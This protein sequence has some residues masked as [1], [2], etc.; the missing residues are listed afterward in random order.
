VRRALPLLLPLLL[1]VACHRGEAPPPPRAAVP[2]ERERM[3]SEQ[4]E[5]RGVRDERVLAAMRAVPREEFVPARLRPHAHEDRPLPIEEGQTISQPYIVAFMTEA[6]APEAADRV[7][8]IGTGSGYQAAV[9]AQLVAGVWS[10][11]LEPR[12]AESARARLERLA[13]R[14]VHLRQ[15]DGYLGWPEQAP[16]DAIVVTCGAEHVPAP[17]VEQ[18]KPGGRLVIPVGPLDDQWLR[19]VEKRADGTTTSRDAFPVRFV[20]LR[21]AAPAGDR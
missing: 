10:I 18:L 17:L 7:L 6:I 13:V 19:I 16:F 2:G 20:P 15:G 9:L 4:I 11:E 14:N 3:V 5:A 1:A 21:R 12:L 8:E